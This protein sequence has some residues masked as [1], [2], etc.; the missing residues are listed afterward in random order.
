M[1]NCVFIL[2]EFHDNNK[3]LS[4]T[5]YINAKHRCKKSVNEEKILYN[6]GL[7][8]TSDNKCK[9]TWNTLEVAK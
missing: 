3:H 5:A 7:T 4:K 2:C 1:E 8:E 6:Q 9:A